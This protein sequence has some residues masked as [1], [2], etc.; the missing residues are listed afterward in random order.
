MKKN[1]NKLEKKSLQEL[2][3]MFLWNVFIR[4]KNFMIVY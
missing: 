4:K 1:G 3:H 2:N